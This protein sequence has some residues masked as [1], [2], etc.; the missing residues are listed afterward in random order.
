MSLVEIKQYATLNEQWSFY[1][2]VFVVTPEK[3]LFTL[4]NVVGFGNIN[5]AISASFANVGKQS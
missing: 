3:S 1:P 5:I 2:T 4:A